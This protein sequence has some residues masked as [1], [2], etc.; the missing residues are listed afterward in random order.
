[1][2]GH[3]DWLMI[4]GHDGDVLTFIIG[5]LIV[6]MG[7]YMNFLIFGSLIMGKAFAETAWMKNVHEPMSDTI[8]V[9]LGGLMVL[10]VMVGL[11]WFILYALGILGLPWWM[12]FFV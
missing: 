7:V 2:L 8:G 1:M 9:F 4:F 12:V 6:L 3:S 11:I 10:T 5:S